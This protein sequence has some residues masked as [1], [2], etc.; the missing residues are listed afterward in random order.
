MDMKAFFD[1]LDHD[2]MMRA[3]EKHIPES[4]IRLYIRR[5]LTCPVI[6]V[7]DGQC[8]SRDRGTPQ[9]GVISPILAN[10]Y[11]HYAFDSWMDKHFPQVPFERYADDI[12]CHCRTES[13]GKAL[14]EAL[15]V[16]LTAC[17]L[18]LH[19]EKTR[20]VV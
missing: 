1:T 9:G 5:W 12:V 6:V 8:Q 7:A 3:V 15:Q 2:L 10:L 13:E 14:F 4:W 17:R 11:L 18:Q 20:L 19:P 16:R